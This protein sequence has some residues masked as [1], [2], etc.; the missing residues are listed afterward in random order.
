MFRYTVGVDSV[1]RR[2][3]CRSAPITAKNVAL[4]ARAHGCSYNGQGGRRD[5]SMRNLSYVFQGE[6]DPSVDPNYFR[7]VQRSDGVTANSSFRSSSQRID[8]HPDFFPASVAT[9]AASPANWISASSPARYPHLERA[10]LRSVDGILL[11]CSKLL[12]V[13]DEVTDVRVRRLLG[14]LQCPLC[15]ENG[16]LSIPVL[17][18]RLDGSGIAG[19]LVPLFRGERRFEFPSEEVDDSRW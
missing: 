8:S 11:E 2:M 10:K 3:R 14:H 7:L 13:L 4:R 12:E 5:A 16:A 1:T 18:G 19:E 15:A 6:R 17:S 9:A